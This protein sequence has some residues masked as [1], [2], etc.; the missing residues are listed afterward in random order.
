[1]WA[2][3]PVRSGWK[4]VSPT[5]G[6]ALAEG[7]VRDAG[8]RKWEQCVVNIGPTTRVACPDGHRETS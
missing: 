2:N 6:D 8:T 1:M 4:W 5:L 3:S 7:M